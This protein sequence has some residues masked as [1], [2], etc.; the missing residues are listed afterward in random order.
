[1]DRSQDILAVI[2]GWEPA[3]RAAAHAMIHEIEADALQRMRLLAGSTSL[4]AW[5]VARA[6]PMGLVTRN[7]AAS[8]AHMHAHHWTHPLA[9]F[10]PAVARDDGLAHK[11]DPAALL[12]CAE[13][14]GVPPSGCVMIGDS[15]RDDVVAGRRAGML[16]ILLT[17]D[18]GRH[19]GAAAANAAA[20]EGEKVPHAMAASMEEVPA[21]LELHFTVPPLCA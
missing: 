10:W 12:R 6:I 17:G 1:V 9:P 15:P 14:W 11:P 16:T 13:T 18:L 4:G 3:R 8:V 7:T 2:S 5:C 20:L 19:G 21:L